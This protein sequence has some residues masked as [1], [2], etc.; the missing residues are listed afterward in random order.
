MDPDVEIPSANRE[1]RRAQAKAG[2]Q[3]GNVATFD[4]LRKKKPRRDTV[5]LSLTGDDGEVEEAIVRIQ[6]ISTTAYDKLVAAHPPTNKQRERGDVYDIDTFGPALI[7]ACSLEPRLTVEEASELYESDEWAPGEIGAW[8]FA[9]QRLCNA[10]L[11]VSF[12]AGG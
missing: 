5:K 9:C 1:T 8:F 4:Q 10:G 11:D 2:K 3:K 12:S 6:A 7:A